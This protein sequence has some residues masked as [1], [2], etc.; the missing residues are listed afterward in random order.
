MLCFV[1]I[2]LPNILVKLCDFFLAHLDVYFAMYF[3]TYIV[4]IGG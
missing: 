2:K 1:Q 4:I 3:C